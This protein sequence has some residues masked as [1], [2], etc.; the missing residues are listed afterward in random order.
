MTSI[1][2][3]AYIIN[4]AYNVVEDFRKQ[5]KQQHGHTNLCR[6]VILIFLIT[7]KI[8]YEETLLPDNEPFSDS[9][10]IK[11]Q[12][13]TKTLGESNTAGLSLSTSTLVTDISSECAS[14]ST[15]ME[16]TK[17]MSLTVIKDVMDKPAYDNEDYE[18]FSDSSELFNKTQC[19]TKTLDES[20]TGGSRLSNSNIITDNSIECASNITHMEATECIPLTVHKD[21]Q[22]KIASDN[23]DLIIGDDGDLTEITLRRS[24]KRQSILQETA[25]CEIERQIKETL[26][27]VMSSFKIPTSYTHGEL[28]GAGAFGKVYL[29]CDCE[30]SLLFAIKQVKL[31]DQEKMSKEVEALIN[32]IKILSNIKHERIVQYYG[33]QPEKKV[34][35]IFL[36][37][38]PGRSVLHHI[39]T[40]G[41]LAEA[42]T[43]QYTKQILEGLVFLHSIGIVHRDIKAA[44]IL[45]DTIGNIKLADFGV[46]KQLENISNASL[47]NTV[48]GTPYWM[49]P[50]IFGETGYGRKVDVCTTKEIIKKELDMIKLIKLMFGS[51]V[52]R[53][54]IILVISLSNMYEDGMSDIKLQ[55]MSMNSKEW[56]E[57][58]NE[59]LKEL[60]QECNY[61]VVLFN[62]ETSKPSTRIE[63]IH[64]LLYLTN[65]TQKYSI[66]DFVKGTFKFWKFLDLNYL[67]VLNSRIQSDLRRLEG[68]LENMLEN[69]SR[70]KKYQSELNLLRDWLIATFDIAKENRAFSNVDIFIENRIRAIHTFDEIV[71]LKQEHILFILRENL[72]N[73]EKHEKISFDLDEED[74]PTEET[75]E[76]ILK[77]ES[78]K[79]N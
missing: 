75:N 6:I 2:T 72:E 24:D 68:K 78:K 50:E 9:S 16:A 11:T 33:C 22:D 15:H 18:P 64:F 52:I 39:K 49:A 76:N 79:K 71:A 66:N 17:C 40:F 37:Y 62:N 73:I 29:C 7:S 44:N 5:Y 26:L 65:S 56:C 25:P 61:R 51:E 47:F 38:M 27:P 12:C 19:D 54:H 58:Q 34:V 53:K 28:L 60:F 23:E 42:V 14:S 46:S 55:Y 57:K 48:V 36:E 35:C 13:D 30:T 69:K 41:Q 8:K 32:E 59:D 1:A 43:R 77:K 3:K 21:V 10:E 45:R 70:P 67:R 31:D 74:I 4:I 20:N 63:Q